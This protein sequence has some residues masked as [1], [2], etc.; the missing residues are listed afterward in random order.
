[1]TRP[2][3]VLAAAALVACAAALG[4]DALAKG[5]GKSDRVRDRIPLA[6]QS[7]QGRARLTIRRD[8]PDRQEVRIQVEGAATGL[9]LRVFIEDAAGVLT[10]VAPMT[11]SRP[12]Q[13]GWRVRTKKGDALPFGQSDL[14]GLSG[15][16]VEVRTGDGTT[17]FAA[18]FPVISVAK[19]PAFSKKGV[20]TYLAVD[21]AVAGAIGAPKLAARAEVRRQR[22]GRQRFGVHIENAVSGQT[23]EVWVQ[24]P[25]TGEMVYLTS[26]VAGAPPAA[27]AKHGA[28]DPGGSGGVGGGADDDS[29]DDGVSDEH[30]DEGEFELD[31]D[32]GD[33]LP[34]GAASVSDLAGLDVQ[35]RTE[36]GD[37]VAAG[38]IPAVG[39]DPRGDDDDDDGIE[40][41][42]EDEVE[43][44]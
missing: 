17:A 32:D 25:V 1:M 21:R 4:G 26:I 33:E 5:G 18:A 14:S 39:D 20:R 30:E 36:S 8:R 35:V 41:G 40:D 22:R 2:R 37:V 29:D 12:G 34:G 43:D 31:T 16:K 7:F 27:K 6:A 42:T 24:D 10:E 23:F 13:Y 3:L 38:E 11:E 19:A 9:D 28:D 15:R 44:D